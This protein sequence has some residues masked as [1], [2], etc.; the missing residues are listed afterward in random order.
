MPEQSS[1]LDLPATLREIVEHKRVEVERAR[2]TAPQSELVARCRDLE[3]ARDFVGSLLAR[4]STGSTAVIAE[5]KRRSP[6]AGLI[7]SEYDGMGFD[8]SVIAQGYSKA[9]ASAI[10]CLTDEKFFGGDPAFVQRIR[11]SVDLPVLRKDFMIDPYQVHEARAMGADAIL[12]IAECL[13]DTQIA[14]MLALAGDLGMGTLLESHDPGNLDRMLRLVEGVEFGRYL[15]G[16][17]N[18][19][20]RTMTTDLAHTTDLVDRVPDRSVL[21]SESGIRTPADLAMLRGHGVRIVLVGEH[22][23]RQPQPGVALGELLA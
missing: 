6:S 11:G 4:A 1:N 5:I 9:G 16:V 13:T 12:L 14:E 21:V 2:S 3:P 17:N 8:P 22:L 10:S 20:L 19:D 15:I 7:R 18:R 23:M